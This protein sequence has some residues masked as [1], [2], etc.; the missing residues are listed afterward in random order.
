MKKI[1]IS[2]FVGIVLL[3]I[4]YFFIQTIK[5]DYQ[6]KGLY[7][8]SSPLIYDQY[9]NSTHKFSFSYP[10]EFDVIAYTPESMSIATVSGEEVFSVAEIRVLEN[11][12]QDS[13]EEFALGQ[14]KNMCAADG[15]GISI[16][17][18][19]AVDIRPFKSINGI[20]GL[21][22]Q[23][24]KE[25]KNMYTDTITQMEEIGPFFVFHLNDLTSLFIL[26]PH[27][28]QVQQKILFTIAESIA[29]D[30]E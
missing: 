17:C 3:T 22:I 6:K 16:T 1:I 13:F 8:P 21:R 12:Q 24:M 9:T 19:D 20:K 14:I 5:I 23:I 30:S 11:T 29:S 26:P 25:E 15:P 27:T 18:T 2:F 28:G 4:G 10:Q 7:N